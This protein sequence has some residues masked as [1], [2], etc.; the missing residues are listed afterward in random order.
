MAVGS[1]GGQAGLGNAGSIGSGGGEPHHIGGLEDRADD[2]RQ[3]GGRQLF[4]ELVVL[5]LPPGR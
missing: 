2:R 1:A 4:A 3:R 5:L